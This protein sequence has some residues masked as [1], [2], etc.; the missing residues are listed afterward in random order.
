MKTWVKALLFFAGFLL[1]LPL[2][3]VL[4]LVL[5]WPYSLGLIVGMTPIFAVATYIG[6]KSP[7]RGA[8]GADQQRS[9]AP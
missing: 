4:I 5:N 7:P 1:S 2:G 6:T 3:L 8:G 9:S